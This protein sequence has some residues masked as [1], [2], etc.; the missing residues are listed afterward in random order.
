MTDFFTRKKKELHI[1]LND[2]QKKAVLHSEGPMLLLACPGSGKTTTMIMRIGYLIE[3]KNVNPN[4]IK[5]ITF[6]RASALDMTERFKRFFPQHPPVD[7]STIHS[8][9]FTITRIYLQK[10][11]VSFDLI[12]GGGKEKHAL[13]KSMLL[14]RLYKEA[15]REDGTEDELT[16][17]STFI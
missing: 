6:S 9:A 2:V 10:T 4:R 5:A 15:L 17:L 11:G 8:L 7:F 14:K 16:A 1:E 3:E 12:E 13:T